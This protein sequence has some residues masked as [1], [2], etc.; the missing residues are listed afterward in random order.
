MKNKPSER[1]AQFHNAIVRLRRG[2]QCILWKKCEF[3]RMTRQK[4]FFFLLNGRKPRFLRNINVK[5]LM[6]TAD[7]FTRSRMHCLSTWSEICKVIRKWISN[8]CNFVQFIVF[9]L[10][11]FRFFLAFAV[12]KEKRMKENSILMRSISCEL[13]SGEYFFSRHLTLLRIETRPG[14]W[15]VML[16]KMMCNSNHG[17]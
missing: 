8:V 10:I 4:C 1:F 16:R 7:N 17:S 11:F 5:L 13:I 12:A 9:N 6:K 15:V 14:M 2:R 3:Y